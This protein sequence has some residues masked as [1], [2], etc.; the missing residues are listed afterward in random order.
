MIAYYKNWLKIFKCAI[1][2]D[3]PIQDNILNKSNKFYY[4]L[5]SFLILDE[6]KEKIYYKKIIDAHN[7][8]NQ[9]RDH[10][11]K[12]K[13]ENLKDF[14]KKTNTT[15]LNPNETF[16][17][18]ISEPLI[19]LANHTKDVGPTLI[20][21]NHRFIQLKNNNVSTVN[22]YYCEPTDLLTLYAFPLEMHKVLFAF[23]YE[24][25]KIRQL[26]GLNSQ[27]T[28]FSNTYFN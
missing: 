8:P 10:H 28:T 24:T 6:K 17:T 12:I 2:K 22:Y 26:G 20:D 14:D 5:E 4:L 27:I 25:N 1:K 3:R 18:N 15:D 7:L 11:F 9:L 23:N 21:G 13:T 16:Y 19:V